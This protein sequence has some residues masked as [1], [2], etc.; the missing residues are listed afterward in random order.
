MKNKCVTFGKSHLIFR[1]YFISLI[2]NSNNLNEAQ[3][4]L[5][6]GSVVSLADYITP[7]VKIHCLHTESCRSKQVACHWRSGYRD[8]LKL[9][10]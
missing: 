3:E 8:I 2:L 1:M 10:V 5:L 7:T 9:K 4:I 6:H